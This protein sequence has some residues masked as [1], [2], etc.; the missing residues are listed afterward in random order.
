MDTY[1][2][3]EFLELPQLSFESGNLTFWTAEGQAF[4]NQPICGDKVRASRAC[5]GLVP[6]GGDYW[7][8]PYPVGNRC[9]YW[10]STE[11]RLIGTLT[12]DE[13]V[14]GGNYPWFSFLISGGCDKENLRVELLI[15]ATEQN[16]AKFAYVTEIDEQSISYPLVTLGDR[17]AFY[18]VFEATGN[19]CEFMRRVV[20]NIATAN[21]MGEHTCIRIVDN[22]TTS[23]INV[24]DFRFSSD[25]P[26]VNL[27]NE[28]GGDPSAPVWGFA[29]LHT[30]PIASL[31]FSGILFWGKFDGPI[32]NSLG[33]CSSSHGIGGSGLPPMMGVNNPLVAFFEGT[34]YRAG[35]RGW[36]QPGH[37]TNGFPQFD[38]WPRFTTL[39]HQQMY[40]DWVKRSYEGGLRLMVAHVLN[41]EFLAYEFSGFRSETPSDDKHAVESQISAMKEIASRHEDWMEIVYSPADARR[42]I[43]QNKL[44]VVLGIEVDSLGNWK[45]EGDCTDDDIRSYLNYLYNDLGVRHLFP[46]HLANNA[47]GGAAIYNDVSAL[48]NRFLRDDYFQVE[49]GS[50]IGVQFRLGEDPGPAVNLYRS[51]ISISPPHLGA[52]YAPPDYSRIPGG[53]RNVEGLTSRGRFFIEEMMRLGMIIDVDHMSHKAVNDTLDIVE[54][55]DYPVVSGHTE[56]QELAWRRDETASVHKCPNE[57]QK[58]L[59]HLERIR[60][61]GGM[62]APAFKQG[63]NRDVGE[64]IDKLAGKVS[65]SCA[66]SSTSWAQA[67]LYAVEKMGGR[68][69]GIGTDTNGFYKLPCPRF[70][71]NAGYFL[72]YHIPG[73][74]EDKQRQVLRDDQVQAQINGV[75]YSTPI[76]D[77]GRYRFE[78]VL[79]GEI[80][81]SLE[82]DIWQAV[83]VYSAG[84][85]PW[86]I[87]PIPGINGRVENLAKGLWV[88]SNEL[89]SSSTYG[90]V[91]ENLT[92]EQKAAY[93]VKIGGAPSASDPEPVCAIY[94]KILPIWQK[95]HAMRGSNV[96]LSRS[97]AGQR[98]FD[99][100]IDGVAHYGMLPDFL[101]DLKNVG[102]TDE[103]LLPLFC[104]AEDYIQVWEQCEQRRG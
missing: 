34:G 24:D 12:S 1:M 102:L 64:V 52:Y 9:K 70:G 11:D 26:Q 85:N 18:R 38:G 45:C 59:D 5:P 69:V 99:I 56:F 43:R 19:N 75:A 51:P 36:L 89:S 97:Y 61:L 67:Y 62:V 103:D 28:G 21:L 94:R 7:D 79:E 73:M 42:I 4:I 72:H 41:N 13:F 77:I 82:C 32:E 35:L 22:S 53:H 10:I 15:R 37:S 86:T 3:H 63:D 17:G 90:I 33:S 44:A 92:D 81:D 68:K 16:R 96:P 23:H 95:W 57:Y 100:N 60:K 91:L 49:D 98:D 76:V 8:G 6:L 88:G 25:C 93:L 31:A 80:Y 47:F 66:G 104:S 78:G 84:L 2:L 101:Q 30:H 87:H 65:K 39:I 46:I 29:D 48:L 83:A 54:Q 27:A 74:G 58:T 14:I 50:E 40:V 71:L 20:L 55:R